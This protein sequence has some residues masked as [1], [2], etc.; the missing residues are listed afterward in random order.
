MQSTKL[1]L[2]EGDEEML[3]NFAFCILNFA[4]S[5]SPAIR[6]HDYLSDLDIKTAAAAEK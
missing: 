1:L 4:F 6:Y 2:C 3:I 5:S